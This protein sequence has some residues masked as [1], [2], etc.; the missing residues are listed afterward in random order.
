MNDENR[1]VLLKLA[2]KTLE[3][4]SAGSELP[5]EPDGLVDE[6]KEKKSCFVTLTKDGQLRG[7]MGHILPVQSLWGD[8]VDNSMEAGFHDPRFSPITK[9]ELQEVKIEISVLSKPERLVYKDG[10]DLLRKLTGKEGVIINS[11]G[12]G[13]VYLPQVWK[14]LPDKVQFLSQLCLKAGLPSDFWKK[15]K[16]I[17]R[18]F[19]VENFEE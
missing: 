6:L 8:V 12:R 11:Y 7:C 18:L 1:Q 10:G 9:E 17:V 5:G 3:M 15:E 2:R 16:L 4:F 19:T 14:Q 13:A